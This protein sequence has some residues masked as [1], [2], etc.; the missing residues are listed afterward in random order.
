MWFTAT[1]LSHAFWMC[2]ASLLL[3]LLL[4]FCTAAGADVN[5][6]APTVSDSTITTST[7]SERRAAAE[8]LTWPS[9]HGRLY[10]ISNFGETSSCYASVQSGDRRVFFL[11]LFRGRLSAQYDDLFGAVADWS[12]DNERDIL[13]ALGRFHRFQ[14]SEQ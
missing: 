13:H 4:L 11:T 5:A 9:G 12:A 10:N 2:L 6:T 1:G 8:A 3:L 7:S 14:L